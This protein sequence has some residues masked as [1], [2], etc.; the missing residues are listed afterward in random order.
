MTYTILFLLL[1]S[2]QTQAAGQMLNKSLFKEANQP[3]GNSISDIL[4]ASSTVWIG[5]ENLSMSSDM[6]DTWKIFTRD[7]GLGKGGVSAFG[8]RNKKLWV[9]TGYDTTGFEGEIRDAGGGLGFTEDGGENWQWFAQPVDPE[10]VTEYQPTS[11]VEENI[12]YDIALTDSTVWIASFV[13]GLRK[14]NY[15]IEDTYWQLITVDGLGFSPLSHLTHQAFSVIYDETSIWAGT[16]GGIHKTSD[17]GKNWT[18]FNHTSQDYSIS[19]NFV[20]ALAH[21]QSN[22]KDR[23]WAATWEAVDTSEYT[24]VSVTRDG[25]LTWRVVLEGVKV[26]N[27][28]FDGDAVYAASSSG[29]FKST[30]FGESWS[31]FSQIVEDES[32]ERVYT[33]AVYSVEIDSFHNIWVGTGDGLA[34]SRDNGQTWEIFR[35]FTPTSLPSEPETYAY[36]NPFSPQRHNVYGG[37][38]QVRFQYHITG[39]TSV[40][41]KVYDF[42]MN[43]VKTVVENKTRAVAGDYAEVWNG[44]NELEEIVANGVYFYKIKLQG[45]SAFW[46]K[47]MVLN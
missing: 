33:T 28:A 19:G 4:I 11:T 38:G 43:L 12:I 20:V 36:P 17:G 23:I 15:I 30:D 22:G 42:G 2:F 1:L 3:G 25:G 46:G 37:D 26:H 24:G 40:T 27:F 34:L 35:S 21:Q 6:G 32:G 45:K 47:V 14:M 44:R 8:F 41:V 18:T 29:L 9:A 5:T 13:G 31:C 7:D 16:A 10:D 39:S